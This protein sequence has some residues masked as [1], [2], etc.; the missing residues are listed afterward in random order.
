MKRKPK[1]S[2]S[3][4]VRVE[5]YDE[6][7]GGLVELLES[8]RRTSAR[9]VNAVMTATYWEIGRRIVAFEQAGEARAEYGEA[10][11]KKLATDL[12]ARFGRGF[13]SRNV[14][15]MRAFYLGWNIL[16]TLSAKSEYPIQQTLSAESRIVQTPY[17]QLA[18]M[19]KGQTASDQSQS[20]SIFQTA[21]GKSDLSERNEF[22]I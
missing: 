12:N 10:L 21:S 16:Q 14:H 22:W 18:K 15:S 7:L 19:R 2:K 5:G 13:S 17:A 3:E 8:S 20:D 1:K 4:L 6:V 9:A 11:I